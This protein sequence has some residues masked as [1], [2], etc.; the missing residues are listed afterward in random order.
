MADHQTSRPDLQLPPLSPFFVSAL[1]L[2][3]PPIPILPSTH[4][5]QRDPIHLPVPPPPRP[6]TFSSSR[7]QLPPEAVYQFQLTDDVIARYPRCQLARLS[8]LTSVPS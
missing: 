5:E 1:G 7:S 2:V 4:S 6:Q 3:L 8:A